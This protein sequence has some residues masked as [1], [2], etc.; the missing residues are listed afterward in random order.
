VPFYD[1]I[2]S[3]CGHEMEVMHSVEGSGPSE[4]PKCHG[5][6][7]KAISAPAIH[8]KGSGWARKEPSSRAGRSFAKGAKDSKES[9]E[10]KPATSQPST[11]APEATSGAASAKDPD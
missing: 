3:N 8:F 9:A 5:Q 2:C 10:S 7:R 11:P 4:C 1:Y 6:M